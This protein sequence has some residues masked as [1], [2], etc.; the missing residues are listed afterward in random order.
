MVGL[1]KRF[2]GHHQFRHMYNSRLWRDLRHVHLARFPLCQWCKDGE[3]SRLVPAT[4]VHHKRAHKGDWVLF[5]DSANLES[6]CSTCHNR[7]AQQQESRGYSTSVEA[8]GWPK[9]N[10]HPVNRKG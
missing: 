7:D 6:L 5:M 2:E 4:V 1:T 9:D 3:P 10:N 8:N